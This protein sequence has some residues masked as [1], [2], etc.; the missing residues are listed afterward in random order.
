MA[1]DKYSRLKIAT[2]IN[3]TSIN[4]FAESQSVTQ[5][6]IKGVCDGSITSARLSKS[7]DGFIDDAEMKFRNH[8]SERKLQPQSV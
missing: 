1:L 3:D 4:E 6:S 7:I 8:L 2:I 5:Q